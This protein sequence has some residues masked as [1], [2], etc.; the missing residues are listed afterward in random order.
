MGRVKELLKNSTF[1]SALVCFYR[2]YFSATRRKFGYIHPSAVIRQPLLIKGVENVYLYENTN[3][4]GDTKILTTLAK[5]IMKKNSG[6]AEGLTV[7]TGNHFSYPGKFWKDIHD[8]DKEGKNLD[9]DVIVEEDVWLASNVTLLSGVTVGRGS[10][11]GSCT[12]CRNSIPPYSI[13]FGNPARIVGF[14]FT[15]EEIIEHEKALY[16]EGERLPLEL[17]EKNYEKY[18][19]KRMKEIKEFTRL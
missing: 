14:R 19:L 17:L 9:R 10:I 15:P 12:V 7:V 8:S 11:V 13:V 18:F 16:P 2:N 4:Y 1:L 5:F 3:I 6:S